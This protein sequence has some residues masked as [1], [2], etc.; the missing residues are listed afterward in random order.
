[1]QAPRRSRL[2]A[3]P[4]PRPHSAVGVG[5][6]FW[7]YFPSYIAIFDTEYSEIFVMQQWYLR[8]GL[9]YL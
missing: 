1:M 2:R 5:Y 4:R 8:N 3:A 7:L 6:I 9:L